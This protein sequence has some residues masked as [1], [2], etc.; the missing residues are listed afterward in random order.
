[1]KDIKRS[2]FLIGL[3]SLISITCTSSQNREKPNI[4]LENQEQ[5]Q[6]KRKE[7]NSY[8][9]ELTQDNLNFK[10]PGLLEQFQL[11]FPNFL[12]PD[13]LINHLF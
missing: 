13:H 4:K 9:D 3:F 5:K 7:L 6:Q 10:E 11:F 12:L 8:K 2:L 1:M